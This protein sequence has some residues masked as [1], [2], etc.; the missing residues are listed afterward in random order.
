[1]SVCHVSH[2]HEWQTG[3]VNVSWLCT[4]IV[5]RLQQQLHEYL[6]IHQHKFCCQLGL[7][8]WQFVL[9]Y[10]KHRKNITFQ[11]RAFSKKCKLH[12]LRF[13]TFTTKSKEC[14]NW[15]SNGFQIRTSITSIKLFMSLKFSREMK[16]RQLTSN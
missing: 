7:G 13:Y 9:A 4:I 5:P 10:L 1:M 12:E 8:E 6:N 3:A 11:Y 14:L 2:Q 16:T 15:Q